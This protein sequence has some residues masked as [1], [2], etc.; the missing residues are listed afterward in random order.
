MH[1]A[2]SSTSQLQKRA[3]I[4]FLNESNINNDETQDKITNYN[5]N[6]IVDN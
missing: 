3:T 1:K 4:S 6:Q 2:L 5:N